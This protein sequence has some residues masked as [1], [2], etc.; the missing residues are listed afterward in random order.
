M[1]LND[2]S[3]FRTNKRVKA[4]RNYAE[5]SILGLVGVESLVFNK[6]EDINSLSDTW[7]LWA[8]VSPSVLRVREFDSFFFFWGKDWRAECYFQSYPAHTDHDSVI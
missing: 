5:R 7:H 2:F 3:G 4:S 1:L 8:F 6:S